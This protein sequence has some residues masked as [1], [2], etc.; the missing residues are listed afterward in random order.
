MHWAAV[1]NEIRQLMGWDNGASFGYLFH[2]GP[3]ATLELGA[4]GT[5]LW[6]WKTS[7]QER[8][9]CLRHGRHAVTDPEDGVVHKVCW[10]HAGLRRKIQAKHKLLYLGDRPGDG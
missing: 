10:R 4:W 8:R 2:S 6:A 3:G 7:C 5:V 1:W 9:W